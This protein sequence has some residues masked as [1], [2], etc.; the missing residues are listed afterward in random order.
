MKFIRQQRR[1]LSLGMAAL[2]V[3]AV[4]YGLI[5]MSSAATFVVAR[6]AE[7]G[8]PGGNARKV[9]SS[10]ASDGSAVIFGGS[11]GNCTAPSDKR[12]R[13]QMDPADVKKPWRKTT[14]ELVLYF[15]IKG[16]PAEYADYARQGAE[17]WS[18]SECLEARITTS[19]PSG[20][21]CVP[22]TTSNQE[23]GS[24]VGTTYSSA[25]NSYTVGARIEFYPLLNTLSASKRRMTTVHEMGHAY[26]LAHRAS[27]SAIMYTPS[28]GENSIIPDATDIHN[29]RVLYGPF[30]DTF[31]ALGDGPVVETAE[32]F[33]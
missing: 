25:N 3:G 19:C 4:A 5:V 31:P 21:F 8:T 29:L 10:L 33:Y 16:L 7:D 11:G 15:D 12:L 32:H 9:T 23:K 28:R 6:E 27:S 13:D 18:R 17:S 2:A 20:S 22:M 30:A 26:R 1:Q 14:P 24:V